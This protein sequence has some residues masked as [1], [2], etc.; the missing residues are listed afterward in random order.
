MIVSKPATG[1]YRA[2]Y[3]RIFKR[4]EIKS[5]N[6]SCLVNCYLPKKVKKRGKP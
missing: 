2:N 1:Q 4:V 6:G 5:S 3:D